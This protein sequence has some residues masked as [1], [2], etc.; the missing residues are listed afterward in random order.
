MPRQGYQ[1][2]MLQWVSIIFNNDTILCGFTIFWNFLS[3]FSKLISAVM[4]SWLLHLTPDQVVQD[5]AI[6]AGGTQHHSAS[7]HPGVYIP[8]SLLFFLSLTV[9]VLLLFCKLFKQRTINCYNCYLFVSFTPR[10]W[11]SSTACGD[12]K[13]WDVS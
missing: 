11:T 10:P 9:P 2:I 7:L 13:C 6:A 1:M 4:A 8:P 5:W 3:L 12:G